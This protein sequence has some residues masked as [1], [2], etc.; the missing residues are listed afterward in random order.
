MIDEIPTL[1]I[2]DV[3]IYNNT[4]IVQDEVLAHRLGLIPLK[5]NKD[6]LRSMSWLTKPSADEPTAGKRH[7]RNTLVL[8]LEVECDWADKGKERLRKGESDPHKL[9]TNSSGK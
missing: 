6:N 9:Y 3:Y 7:D 8:E 4:S 2:E 1:A 5:G